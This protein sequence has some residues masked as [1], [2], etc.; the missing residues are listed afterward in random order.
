VKV[1][2]QSFTDWTNF[3]QVFKRPEKSAFN[4]A[5][6]IEA[7]LIETGELD[8]ELAQLASKRK[9][10][11]LTKEHLELLTKFMAP[12]EHQ[13]TVDPEITRTT[14][15]LF[16]YMLLTTCM[17]MS[18]TRY[19]IKQDYVMKSRVLAISCKADFLLLRKR[20]L[21]LVLLSTVKPSNMWD[22]AVISNAFQLKLYADKH[23]RV[24]KVLG[25]VSNF[26][27]YAFTSYD[28]TT[29]IF[30][31]SRQYQILNLSDGKLNVD[32][33]RH[34]VTIITGAMKAKNVISKS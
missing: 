5:F 8:K 33:L 10:E 20:K 24:K 11:E 1:P 21:K 13:C 28:P 9:F 19:M 25:S 27:N 3:R 18:P 7:D 17:G 29:K 2:S 32:E 6:A 4:E 23:H 34:V 14:S 31:I 22:D 15:T 30:N 12:L 16:N 26:Y